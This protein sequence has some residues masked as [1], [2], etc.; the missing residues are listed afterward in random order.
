MPFL[1]KSLISAYCR[2][3]VILYLKLKF[4]HQTKES[5]FLQEGIPT[6]ETDTSKG[7]AGRF[8]DVCIMSTKEGVLLK[9]LQQRQSATTLI[10]SGDT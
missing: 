10:Y 9:T 2:L 7:I 5:H 4:D 1:C 3:I 8:R 6:L